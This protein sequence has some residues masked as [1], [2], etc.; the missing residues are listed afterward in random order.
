M[1]KRESIAY[2]VGEWGSQFY[3]ANCI[4]FKMFY[5]GQLN[6][7]YFSATDFYIFFQRRI[8]A[9]KMRWYCKILLISY[10]DHV[11]NEEVLAKIQLAVWPHEDHLTIVKR[12][13]LQWYGH[14]SLY[15]VWPKLS[16]KAQWEGEEEKADRGRG[17]KTT[18]GNGQAWSLPSPRGQW[19][20][21]KDGGNWLQN[22]LW[23]PNNPG[24]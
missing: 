22:H 19:R 3:C 7:T 5:F 4:S 6:F 2:S 23:C 1:E 12:C 18:L 11:T 24:G 9:M 16:C 21:G 14:V 13:K 17:G 8:Q 20:T 10:K 15:Q